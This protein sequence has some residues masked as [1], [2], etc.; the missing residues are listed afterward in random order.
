MHLHN[1]NGTGPRENARKPLRIY[2]ADRVLQLCVLIREIA[3]QASPNELP[4]FEQVL[5]ELKETQ[6]RIRKS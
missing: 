4:V 5:E 6:C 3:E 1:N 2:Y